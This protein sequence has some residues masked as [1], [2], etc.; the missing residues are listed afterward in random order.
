[1]KHIQLEPI[2][3][4]AVAVLIAQPLIDLAVTMTD[5]CIKQYS[6]YDGIPGEAPIRTQSEGL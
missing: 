5:P 1:M 3:S 6:Q 4:T 2:H